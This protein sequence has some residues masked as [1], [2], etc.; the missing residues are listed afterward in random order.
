[1]ASVVVL[2]NTRWLGT[3]PTTVN[4]R[5][6]MNAMTSQ[7]F[8]RVVLFGVAAVLVNVMITWATCVVAALVQ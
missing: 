5:N 2:Y 1:M 4:W 6:L 7:D 8:R 3:V